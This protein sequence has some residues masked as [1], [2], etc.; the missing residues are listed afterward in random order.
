ME[1]GLLGAFFI[2]SAWVYETWK[3][4]KSKEVPDI[5]FIAFYVTG[6]SLLTLY[7]IQINNVP[8]AFLNGTILTLTLIELDLALRR[9]KKK[10]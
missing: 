2:L 8:F 9:H 6:L 1:I 7:S 10:R 3:A 4:Y 5:K